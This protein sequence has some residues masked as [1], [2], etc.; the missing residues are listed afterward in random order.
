MHLPLIIPT[1]GDCGIRC[2]GQERRWTQGKV[3]V[4]DDS[5]VHEVWN[6]SRYVFLM[7]KVLLLLRKNDPEF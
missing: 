1:S 4:L 6:R 3:L 7:T 5:Y 2:G